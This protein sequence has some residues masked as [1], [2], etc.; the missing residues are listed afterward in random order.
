MAKLSIPWP[1]ALDCVATRRPGALGLAVEASARRPSR[2][3]HRSVSLSACSAVAAASLQ[4]FLR[5]PERYFKVSKT[6]HM[7]EKPLG[8]S[9]ARRLLMLENAAA[10]GDRSWLELLVEAGVDLDARNL[11]GQTALFIASWFG[12]AAVVRQLL[13][14]G[15]S[16]G[17]DAAGTSCVE[18]AVQEGHQEV[19][20][21]LGVEGQQ[22][23]PRESHVVEGAEALLLPVNSWLFPASFSERFLLSLDA[24]AEKLPFRRWRLVAAQR[25]GCSSAETM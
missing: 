23:L 16:R 18:V 7:V 21:L 5:L 14:L 20:K 11:F 10:L 12:H 19:L 17:V 9:R 1:D 8:Q 2:R 3:N 25:S 6:K 15:A 4:R 13:G 24:L 22:P